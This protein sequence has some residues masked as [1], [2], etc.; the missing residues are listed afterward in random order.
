MGTAA[1]TVFLA[2]QGYDW[3]GEHFVTSGEI[4]AWGLLGALIAGLLACLWAVVTSPATTAF[5]KA[6][7]QAVQTLL[8]L[9]IAG[10]AI[11]SWSEFTALGKLVVPTVA[12]VVIAFIV[13]YLTN[14]NPA[15]QITNAAAAAPTPGKD[16]LLGAKA[17]A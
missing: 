8:G 11:R 15:P 16:F 3:T 10:V 14:R 7:R 12:A 17:A 9:P 2:A 4:V 5:G 1:L 13:S 6:L